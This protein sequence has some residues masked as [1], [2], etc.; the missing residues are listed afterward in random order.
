MI[1]RNIVTQKVILTIQRSGNIHQF[2]IPK[3]IKNLLSVT[4]SP[5]LKIQSLLIEE[6]KQHLTDF[7]SHELQITETKYTTLKRLST[8]VAM[9]I[10]KPMFRIGYVLGRVYF[11]LTENRRWTMHSWLSKPLP[12]HDSSK[13]TTPPTWHN[14]LLHTQ[15]FKWKLRFRIHLDEKFWNLF[16]FQTW[17]TDVEFTKKINLDIVCINTRHSLYQSKSERA[18]RINRRASPRKVM[19][20][21]MRKYFQRLI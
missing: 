12:A 15:I 21:R 20:D 14:K 10:I 5:K 17:D 19:V 16:F 1:L 8:G 13:I 18:S 6:K 3:P 11:C 4:Q 9:N 7:I 2:S